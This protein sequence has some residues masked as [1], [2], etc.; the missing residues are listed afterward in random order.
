MVIKLSSLSMWPISE[1]LKEQ[2]QVIKIISYEVELRVL[3]SRGTSAGNFGNA[4]GHQ[5][6]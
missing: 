6:D 4:L 3:D 2:F 1:E 5:L